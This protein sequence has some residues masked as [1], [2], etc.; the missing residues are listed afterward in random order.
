MALAVATMT[1][2]AGNEMAIAGRF[3]RDLAVAAKSAYAVAVAGEFAYEVAVA[4]RSPRWH[5]GCMACLNIP[6]D[7]ELSDGKLALQ[8]PLVSKFKE[9]HLH[10]LL[11][12]LQSVS[13]PPRLGKAI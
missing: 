3:A 13:S 12:H 2:V 4:R 7:K 9:H 5:F 6:N 11:L 8:A 10:L 1:A